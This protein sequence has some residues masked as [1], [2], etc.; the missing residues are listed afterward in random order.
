M[1]GIPVDELKFLNPEY[2]LGIIPAYDGQ[3][4]ELRL[5]RRF[6]DDFL[7]NEKALYAYKTKAGI[8][9][10][11]LMAIIKK[12]GSREIHIVKWGEN[13]GSIARMY[14]VYVSQLR[15]WNRLRSD[16]IYKGQRLL[17]YSAGSPQFYQKTNEPISRSNTKT[18]YEVKSGEN[19]ALIAKKYKC[20]TTDLVEWNNLKSST[21]YPGEKLY[22]YQ[23][24]DKNTSTVRKGKYIYH[25]IKRGDTLWDIAQ[26]YDGVT[27]SQ[28]K[29]LN[30][31]RNT[32]HLVPGQKL[33]IAVA[34]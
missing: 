5:P 17:V 11:K 4:Y 14:H 20:S 1:L 7:N 10:D 13:L 16:R 19:L 2:K 30:N 26:E 33:I 12:M 27:V 25:I 6:T 31:I 22:V 34:S 8:A 21:I 18:L 28:I 3:T 23:P 29:R 15:R 32:R 24:A 9:H